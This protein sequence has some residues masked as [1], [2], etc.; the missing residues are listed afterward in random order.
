MGAR[1]NDPAKTHPPDTAEVTAHIWKIHMTINAK[2]FAGPCLTVTMLAALALPTAHAQPRNIDTATPKPAASN[3]T[4]QTT[5]S[6]PNAVQVGTPPAPYTIY[7]GDV[8]HPQAGDA[9]ITK[10]PDPPPLPLPFAEFAADFQPKQIIP[11]WLDVMTGFVELEDAPPPGQNVFVVEQLSPQAVARLHAIE[12]SALVGMKA[13]Y[14][15]AIVVDHD[16]LGHPLDFTL[17]LGT[18]VYYIA[19][20]DTAKGLDFSFYYYDASALRWI[21]SPVD[22][23]LLLP[24]PVVVTQKQELILPADRYLFML[25]SMRKG[26][27]LAGGNGVAE[28]PLYGYVVLRVHKL[29]SANPPPETTPVISNATGFG[30]VSAPSAPPPTATPPPAAA[31]P[32]A[33]A[34]TGGAQP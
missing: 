14:E 32:A 30:G 9:I 8:D 2:T 29:V 18:I 7:Q 31:A 4:A 26:P 24:F 1:D 22:R 33:P 19:R 3:Q 28:V 17:P 11:R 21:P 15:S 6:L 13:R 20:E 34:T 27:P 23:D 10:R 25:T 12:F 16:P 5:P